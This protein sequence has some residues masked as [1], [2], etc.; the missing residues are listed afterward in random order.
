MKKNFTAAL[1]LATALGF[2]SSALAGGGA[3][4]FLQDAIR[5]NAAEAQLAEL[6]QEKSETKAV[7]DYAAT[8]ERDHSKALKE[9][10]KLADAEGVQAPAEP[11]QDAKQMY[12]KLQGMSGQ[13]FDRAFMDHMVQDHKKD[14]EKFTDAAQ[15]KDD[16]EASQHASEVLPV[17]K[18]HLETAQ[19]LQANLKGKSKS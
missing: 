18:R 9:A 5:G 17:L 3:K 16:P 1:A 10:Q 13:A 12:K 19:N 2:A 6:A 8:L 7:Q 11:T 15:N 14:I 4:A